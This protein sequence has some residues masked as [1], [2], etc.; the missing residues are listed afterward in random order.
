MTNDSRAF[1]LNILILSLITINIFPSALFENLLGYRFTSVPIITSLVITYLLF[2]NYDFIFAD[3]KNKNYVLFFIITT[4]LITLNQSL[5]EFKPLIFLRYFFP[6]I[7]AYLVFLYLIKNNRYDI[8]KVIMLILLFFIV[9]FIIQKYNIFNLHTGICSI[10]SKYQ[11]IV[12]GSCDEI[13]RVP[14][15]LSTEPS[16]HALSVFG[17]LILYKVY[18]NQ[19][20]F[21]NNHQR[22]IYILFLFNILIISST[23]AAVL[24]LCFISY[25]LF[26]YFLR[27]ENKKKGFLFFLTILFIPILFIQS[28]SITKKFNQTINLATN[29]TISSRFFYNFTSIKNIEIYPKKKFLNFRGNI[30]RDLVE[31]KNLIKLEKFPVVKIDIYKGNKF[32]LNSSLLYFIYDFGLLLSIPFLLFNLIILKNIFFSLNTEKFFLILPYYSVSLFA[33]SNFA[34][35]LMWLIL[36]YI[37][38]D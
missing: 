19:N 6:V 12:R 18:G 8:S 32:N 36:F 28:N 13:V 3:Y 20:T 24:L 5:I 23:L 14:T 10:I 17:L 31:E 26:N 9:I 29:Q 27:L 11:L 38:K 25:L 15:F 37:C 34:N 33:Q 1:N 2:T 4:F 35:I 22:K 16:Y 21:S 7:L 30:I